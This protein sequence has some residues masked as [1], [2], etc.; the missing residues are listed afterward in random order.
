MPKNVFVPGLD[1]LNLEA[2]RALPDADR[3]AFHQPREVYIGASDQD[4]LHARYQQCVH[5]LQ[6]AFE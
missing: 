4:E 2:M 1:E 5:E 6:F 3:S